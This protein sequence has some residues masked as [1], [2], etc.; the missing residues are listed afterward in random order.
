ME[1]P[2]SAVTIDNALKMFCCGKVGRRKEKVKEEVFYSV[3]E[4]QDL[5]TFAWRQLGTEGLG[6]RVR[7]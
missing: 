1:A 3:F 7:A 6:A 2:W 5:G 4:M